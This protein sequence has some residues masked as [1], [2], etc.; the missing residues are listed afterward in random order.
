[1]SV[2]ALAEGLRPVVL[3]L[4]RRLRREADQVGLSSLDAT[5]LAMVGKHQGIG[6][7]ELADLERTSRPTMSNHVKRLEAAALIARRPPE[8]DRRRVG[9]VLTPKG[10]RAIEVLRRRRTDWLAERLAALSDE[11]RE[12]I[13]RAMEPLGQL[14]AM[15]R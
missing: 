7:S 13:R 5:L 12:A 1:M 14:A 11:Q 15:D 3:R 2:S 9:L 4:G 8:R 6:V 10:A